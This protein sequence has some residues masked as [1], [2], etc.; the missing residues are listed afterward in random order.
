MWRPRLTPALLAALSGAEVMKNRRNIQTIGDGA[1]PMFGTSSTL[2]EGKLRR[3]LSRLAAIGAALSLVVAGSACTSDN[4]NTGEI[5]LELPSWQADDGNFENWLRPLVEQ[6][7]EQHDGITVELQPV[8]FDG[9]V[10]QMTTRFAASNPPEILHLPSANFTEFASKGWLSPIDERLADTD[11]V[12]SWPKLQDEMKWEDKYMGVLLLGY[13]QVLFYNKALL[14]AAGVKV[15]TTPT[16]LVA[17]GKTLTKGDVFGFGATTAQHPRNYSEPQAWLVGNGTDF[18]SAD[19]FTVATPEVERALSTY[20]ELMQYAPKGITTQ[21]RFELFS[22][23][24]IAMMF[25]GPFLIPSIEATPA[26][27]R[28]N[29]LVAM[30]PLPQVAGSTSNGFHIPRG[31]DPKVEDAVWSFIQF[32]TTQEWQAKYA[33]L[34]GVPAPRK[35]VVTDDMVKAQPRLEIIQQAADRAVQTTPESPVLKAEF[36]RYS[37]MIG[38]QMIRMMSTDDDLSSI[39]SDLQGQLE[40]QFPDLKNS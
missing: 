21:Q 31:L 10:D 1:N 11:I 16:E 19:K 8:P 39:L 37:D 9:F 2:K 26:D 25:D 40:R 36:S 17:A 24:K 7:N 34:L 28:K 4:Q 12:E 3:T 32:A 15:P 29:L 22:Q 23:G 35:G 27:V 5:V 13:G 38:Q 14:D 33:S 18:S 30:P 20:R 6:F